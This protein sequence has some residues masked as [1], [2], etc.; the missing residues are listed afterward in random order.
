MNLDK[1]IFGLLGVFAILAGAMMLADG[2]SSGGWPAI[3][4][5]AAILWHVAFSNKL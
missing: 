3:V 4:I 1:K 2:D 5:G